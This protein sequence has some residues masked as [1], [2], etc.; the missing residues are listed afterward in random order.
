MNELTG[1]QRRYLR[2]LAHAL[3]PHIMVGKAGV[4]DALVTALDDS[5]LAHELVKVKFND[6]KDEKRELAETL[7]ERTG[8]HLV[9][10]LGNI[11]TLYRPH[12]DQEQ[13]GIVL[14]G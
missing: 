7:R 1:A 13:R 14:P 3:R 2:G 6:F 8:S 5:L 9:G 10:L 4:T 12:P 11:A